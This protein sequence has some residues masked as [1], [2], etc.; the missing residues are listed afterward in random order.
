MGMNDYELKRLEQLIHGFHEAKKL[1]MK[2]IP[3]GSAAYRVQYLGYPTAHNF[4]C[5]VRPQKLGRFNDALEFFGVWYGA[6]HPSGALAETFGRLRSPE[7]KGLG[8]FISLEDNCP[9]LRD[10]VGCRCSSGVKSCR[11]QQTAC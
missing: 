2:V 1:P 10:V 11:Y 3:G 9:K 8:L 4:G 5:P 6:E 7:Q